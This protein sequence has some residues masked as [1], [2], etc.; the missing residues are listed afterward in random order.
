MKGN[1]VIHRSK[2]D[3]PA[4]RNIAAEPEMVELKRMI[5]AGELDAGRTAEHLK[6]GSMKTKPKVTWKQ[7]TIRLPA[8]VHRALKIRV[9]EEGRNMGELVEGLVRQ[10]LV[11][12][13]K[14]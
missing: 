11:G 14:A 10:W 4:G 7:L 12:G 3:R 1:L 6:G 9:A 5:R 8:D 2:H 13:K